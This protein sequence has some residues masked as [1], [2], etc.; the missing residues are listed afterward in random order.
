MSKIQDI[1][2]CI[3]W[4]YQF[5]TYDD[6]ID[7]LCKYIDG[8]QED[9]YNEYYLQQRLSKNKKKIKV[10]KQMIET[11]VSRYIKAHYQKHLNIYL[12]KMIVNKLYVPLHVYRK[13]LF[14]STPQSSSDTDG[15]FEYVKKTTQ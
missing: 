13:V 6:D 11:I 1:R 7:T 2:W 15:E 10:H 14:P 3:Q 9:Y 5:Y 8:W 12:E 4:S